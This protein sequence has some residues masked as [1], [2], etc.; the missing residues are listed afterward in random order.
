VYEIANL[1][2]MVQIRLR[3]KKGIIEKTEINHF[4]KKH[5]ITTSSE[6]I[7]KGLVISLIKKENYKKLKNTTLDRSIDNII[8]SK[9]LD[10][11]QTLNR[12]YKNIFKNNIFIHT[13]ENKTS[14]DYHQIKKDKEILLYKETVIFNIDQFIKYKN[15]I[16]I[17]PYMYKNR[18]LKNTIFFYIRNILL[19]III[20]KTKRK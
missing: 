9:L 8:L 20:A 6:K 2:V 5:N 3:S 13:I 4:H 12:I 19:N 11:S 7:N 14:T 17:Y 1:I 18:L 10:N 15:Y 16:S